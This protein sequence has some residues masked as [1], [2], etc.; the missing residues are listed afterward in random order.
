MAATTP[1]SM[2]PQQQMHN[3]QHQHRSSAPINI[4]VANLAGSGQGPYRMSFSPT[5]EREYHSQQQQQQ[6]Q[7][8]NTETYT[9]IVGGAARSIFGSSDDEA[10]LPNHPSVMESRAYTDHQRQQFLA[11]ERLASIAERGMHQTVTPPS[12]AGSM[13]PHPNSNNNSGPTYTPLMQSRPS[14][15]SFPLELQT[16]IY[17][18]SGLPSPI[19]PSP[20]GGSHNWTTAIAGKRL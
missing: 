13:Q 3:S 4:N 5:S 16:G 20:I 12:S 19:H 6:Q 10:Y 9:G 17:S 14:V 8:V 2:R 1:L 15:P 7:S 11:H 18:G